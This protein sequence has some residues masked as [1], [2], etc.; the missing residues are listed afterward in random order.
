[1][2]FVGD[3]GRTGGRGVGGNLECLGHEADF[4]SRGCEE[5]LKSEGETNKLLGRF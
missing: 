2:G 3:K 1:M 5:L 4:C